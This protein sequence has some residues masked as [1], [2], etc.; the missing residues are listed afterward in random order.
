MAALAARRPEAVVSDKH[1]SSIPDVCG[2]PSRQL[3]S[4][5][6]LLSEASL[7]AVEGTGVPRN[8]G[9]TAEGG[10]RPVGSQEQ[11]PRVSEL[12]HWRGGCGSR[13]AS[14]GSSLSA[15]E[16]VTCLGPAGYHLEVLDP[17]T[18]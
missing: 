3:L 14:G 15:R 2:A 5:L 12:A 6:R 8:S 16:T 4:R 1:R 7:L 18:L 11:V 10:R 17:D 9:V 13:A